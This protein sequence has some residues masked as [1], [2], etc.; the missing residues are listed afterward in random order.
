MTG[1]GKYELLDRIAKGGM[2][3]LYRGRVVSAEGFSKVLAIKRILPEFADDQ[4]FVSMLIDEARVVANLSHPNIVQVFELGKDAGGYFIVMEF[5][6]GPNLGTL[7]K[8]LHGAGRR[9]PEPIAL[10]VM[11]AVLQALDF[12]H[13]LTDAAGVPVNLVHRD[14]SPQNVLVSDSGAIKLGDFG[15]AKAAHRV[16]AATQAGS[17]KGKVPYMAPEQLRGEELDGR[18]DQFAAGLVLWECLAGERH[19][20]GASDIELMRQV[21]AARIRPLAEVGA[22]ISPE[23]ESILMRALSADRERRF[24]TCAEMARELTVYHRRTYPA[25]DPGAL[26]ALV[27]ELFGDQLAALTERLRLFE[28][29]EERPSGWAG[30]T[31]PAAID[32]SAMLTD[33][34]TLPATLPQITAE[35]RL[36]GPPTRITSRAAPADAEASSAHQT[37]PT[38]MRSRRAGPSR[39]PTGSRPALAPP[40]RQGAAPRR[41]RTPA[42]PPSPTPQDD[43]IDAA[44]AEER[45]RETAE[46]AKKKGIGPLAIVAAFALAAGSVYVIG[47]LLS[48]PESMQ[49]I[50]PDEMAAAVGLKELPPA[51]PI[52]PPDAPP[53]S[54][55][56]ADEPDAPARPRRTASKRSKKEQPR[57]HGTLDVVCKPECRIEIDGRDT[58]LWSPVRGIVLSAGKHKLRAYNET[59]NLTKT[60]TVEILADQHTYQEVNLVL[61]P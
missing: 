28:S 54:A 16:A 21:N 23:L 26:T 52:L 60:V 4:A 42:H 59:L 44:L 10:D 7:L 3:E 33:P 49:P 8:R 22:P 19:Y 32:N 38:R 61:G 14:V 2:A 51:E 29:G 37:V 50:P 24:P 46:K 48:G 45:K 40:D 15:I 43:A 56:A 41:S 27:Q 53:A 35:A 11:I 1:A 18:T 34:A 13:R 36:D 9:L 6:N 30:G 47:E 12:A 20:Q 31:E 57:G 5:V 25:H 39:K 58:G 55:A 17:I